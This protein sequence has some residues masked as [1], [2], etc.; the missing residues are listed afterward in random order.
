MY[1]IDDLLPLSA[2]Q[3][4]VF[5]ER[6]CA[7]IYTEQAWAENRLTVEGKIMHERVHDESRESRG[8]VRIDYGVSLRSLRLGLIGKADVVEFHHRPDGSWLPFPVEYKRG[9]PKAD[10]CD[11]VQ[12]CAQAICLEEMLSVAIPEGALFYG[13]TKHRLDV[14]FDEALR[15]ETEETARRAHDLVAS[16][17]TPPPIYEKRCESCSLMAECLPKTMQ[18][19]RSVNDYLRSLTHD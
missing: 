4:I 1:A 19:Q 8:D 9:K 13:Q 6:Q 3:H 11:K 18:R 12:L 7:L 16:G 15:R 17:R 14:V 5:C 10:D 2:L